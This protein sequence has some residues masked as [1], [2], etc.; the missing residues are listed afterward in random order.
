[1]SDI[2]TRADVSRLFGRAAFG[3]T[4]AD[5]TK[6]AGQPYATV[7][8]SL[9]PPG[10][11][12]TAGRL[13]DH[14]VAEQAYNENQLSDLAPA[15]RWW[16]ERMRTTTYPLEERMTLFWHDH[17][18]TAY[19]GSPDV[20]MVMVQNKTLRAN[21]LGSFRTLAN[22]MT[23]D[24]AMLVWLNGIA[25]RAGGVNENYAREFLELFTLGVKPQVYTE[26]DIR[27]AAK[28][29]TGWTANTGIR[30]GQFTA[31]RHDTTVKTVLGRTVGGHLPGSPAEALEY[32]EVLEAALAHDGGVTASRFVAYKLV[33][34]FG[35]EPDAGLANDPVVADVAAALRAGDA[36][37]IRAAVRTMFLH[38][39][40]RYA[41]RTL[42][43]SPIQMLI[44]GARV[45]NFPSPMPYGSVYWPQAVQPVMQGAGQAPFLPPNVGGWQHGQGW[46]SQTTNLGRYQALFALVDYFRG[47]DWQTWA[48]WP[49]STDLAGWAAY[50]GLPGFGTNTTLRLQEYLADP[51]VPDEK[52]RQLS[53][54]LLAGSSPEWQVM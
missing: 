15:Q 36:W 24:C 39:G 50:M 7:V 54:F 53:M 48:P 31:A 35:Y 20:G 2:A 4:A 21:A 32:Q 1:M 28:A 51:Q 19:L 3:A 5:L 10:P 34:Q 9:F 22:A 6:W 47:M 43:R 44:H 23:V 49:A 41:T 40:W 27:E 8:D 42:V 33:Q 38:D 37:D 12:G 11:P 30:V 26:T 29:F 14:D 45:L 18:A 17:F 25:N 13:P 52:T 46:L 16:L